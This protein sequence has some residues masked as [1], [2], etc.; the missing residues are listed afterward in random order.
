[1][2]YL[3]VAQGWDAGETAK[4][5]KAWEATTST[6][7]SASDLTTNEIQWQD[8]LTRTK[9]RFDRG[10]VGLVTHLSILKRARD[11]GWKPEAK[12]L[13]ALSAVQAEF[14]L[15]SVGGSIFIID[16]SSLDR[17]GINGAAQALQLHKRQD[18]Q[19]LITRK[20]TADFPHTDKSKLVQK[21]MQAASTTL[22]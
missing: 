14:A 13:D 18:G 8:L 17:K 22:Y 15:I 21:F 5:K 6:R 1:M 3:V 16:K 10:E 2:A 12:E 7:L 11:N 4:I 9:E 19:L 20:L